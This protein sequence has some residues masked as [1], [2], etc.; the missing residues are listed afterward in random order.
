M[1]TRTISIMSSAGPG[2]N[3]RQSRYPFLTFIH[4]QFHGFITENST[5]C[6]RV[7]FDMY[8]VFAE[9]SLLWPFLPPT[10]IFK[11]RAPLNSYLEKCPEFLPRP[12]YGLRKI[13]SS[14]ICLYRDLEEIQDSS[15]SIGLH[16]DLEK[17]RAPLLAFIWT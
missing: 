10:N 15:S 5:H 11:S 2:K 3:L 14:F 8:Y 13:S 9:T 12:L 17:F 4:L 6:S 7:F 16:R 1:K